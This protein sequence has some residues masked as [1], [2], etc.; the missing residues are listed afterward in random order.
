MLK[1]TQFNR[2]LMLVWGARWLSNYS[3]DGAGL[4]DHAP[5]AVATAWWFLS[6]AYWLLELSGEPDV[7]LTE[8]GW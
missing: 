3:L 2:Q 4:A 8:V 1:L 6:A 5:F 7:L